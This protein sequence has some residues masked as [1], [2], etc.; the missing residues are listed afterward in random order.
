[1]EMSER[2]DMMTRLARLERENNRLKGWGIAAIAGLLTFWSV[3]GG[4]A[5]APRELKAERFV[6]QD[7]T[8]RQ[9]ARLGL[10]RDG[11]TELALFDQGRYQLAARGNRDGLT[12]FDLFDR[13]NDRVTL[14]VGPL[15]NTSL[16]FIGPDRRASSGLYL[17]PG[18]SMGLEFRQ[19][20]QGLLLGIDPDGSAQ[21]ML[22]DK[23]GRDLGGLVSTPAGTL[24]S[25]N[26]RFE[27][28]ALSKLPPTLKDGV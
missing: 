20:G 19:V 7:S 12:S 24:R 1:M 25:I 13:G 15:G 2:D 10:T 21:L 4:L 23:D 26:R 14:S 3:T 11:S 5:R 28:E 17:E 22:S 8:G 18:G 6:V 27:R 9:R 16:A